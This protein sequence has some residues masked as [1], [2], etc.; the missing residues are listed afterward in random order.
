[1]SQKYLVNFA[2]WRGLVG[3]DTSRG[4]PPL[5][6]A[7]RLFCMPLSRNAASDSDA[8]LG[9]VDH[10]SDYSVSCLWSWT[11][12]VFTALLCLSSRLPH[13]QDRTLNFGLDLGI[14][15][16]GHM[17]K[18]DVAADIDVCQLATVPG[19]SGY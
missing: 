1:M 13:S 2:Y 5:L 18:A 19:I 8:R 9:R 10:R 16:N 15:V 12:A 11:Q 17:I 6:C 4:A 3:V 14:L 7:Q